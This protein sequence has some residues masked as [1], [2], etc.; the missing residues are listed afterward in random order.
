MAGTAGLA[1]VD[2]AV[3]DVADLTDAGGAV[4][5]DIADFAGGQADLREG[6]F[7]RQKLRGDAGAAD[8]LS[9]GAGLETFP[10]PLSGVRVGPVAFLGIP[11]EPFT[12]IG[13]GLKDGSPFAMTLPCFFFTVSITLAI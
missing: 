3:V 2:V 6:V 13:R 5:A 12:G 8:E 4:H 1:D 10:L 11:G 9:A 7:L